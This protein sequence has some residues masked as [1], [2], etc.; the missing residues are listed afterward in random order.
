MRR[1]AG[2]T[3]VEPSRLNHINTR[4]LN[5]GSKFN[6]YREEQIIALIAQK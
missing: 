4:S 2:E 5:I 6:I 3:A 1:D